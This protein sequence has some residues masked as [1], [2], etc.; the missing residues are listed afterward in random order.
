[1][2]RRTLRAAGLVA[3]LALGAAGPADA[4]PY[5]AIY[6]FGDSLSDA[7]NFFLATGGLAPRPPYSQGRFSNGP[8]WVQDLATGLGLGPLTPSLA[9]GN[10]FAYGEAQ[11]GTTPVHAATAIDLPSQLQQYQQAHPAAQSGALYTLW[12]GA[13]DLSSVLTSPNPAA[14]AGPTIAAAIANIGTFIDGL[15]QAGAQH[16][17]VVDVPDLGTTPRAAAAGGQA[18]ATAL[19]A[20]FD[21]ALGTLLQAEQ[22]SGRLDVHELDSFSLIDAAVA[23]P[24]EYGFTDVKSPCWTGD[25][26]GGNGTLC[27]TDP[28]VQDTHLFWDQLHPTERG[29][30]LIGAAALTLVTPVPEPSGLGVLAVGFTLL[31]GLRRRSRAA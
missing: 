11:T 31:A 30:A 5:D 23:N 12:I 14:V 6:A 13:N 1:M 2:M 15:A 3:G 18:A 28:A 17:L 7:G 29:H 22:A 4:A 10:D 26:F 9:G 24:S 8:V 19:S 25:Y 21:V 16:L 20:A 27:S